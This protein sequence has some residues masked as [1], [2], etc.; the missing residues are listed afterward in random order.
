MADTE[1]KRFLVLTADAG[2]GHRSAANAVEAALLETHGEECAVDIV[3]PLDDPRVLPVLRNSGSD[4]DRLVREM[5][6]LY[7]IGYEISDARVPTAMLEGALIVMLY[8]VLRDVMD[9]VK[10]DAIVTTYPLYQSPL[11]ALS[12]IRRQHVP[13]ITVV[14]DLATVHHIWFNEAADEC[15]VAT[16][17]VRDLA[18]ASGFEADRV[19][20]T[21]IPVHPSVIRESRAP[22][23]IR[24]ALGWP[25]RTDIKTV[26]AVGSKRVGNLQGVVRALNHSG[27]PLHLV[28]VAGGDDE[29]Y[30]ELQS[31]EWHVPAHVYN[32]VDNM[33]EL[34]HAS[35]CVICKAGGLIVTESL[36]CGLPLLLVDVLPGQETGNADYVIQ[37]GAGELS[38]TPLD[39]L[40]TLCHW[41]LGG[42]VGLAQRAENAR[43]L[44]KPRAAY[45]V[46]ER[47]W[48]A[49]QAGPGTAS[50]RRLLHRSR[51]VA[52]L[53]RFQVPKV[54]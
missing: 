54:E 40:E 38:P 48:A 1:K 21:G 22:T 12:V 43:R 2:F 41:L 5:P 16:P 52:L 46:A 42:G 10:P 19:H 31:E 20:I 50:R 3:S 35:D 8:E 27:L 53:G 33:P 11:G 24:N 45:D 9:R 29:L 17:T 30:H 28:V 32:F 14:T 47:A 13:L 6:D 51:L 44:G 25:D 34:M 39:G 49:T 36:A 18:L 26:L 15:L 7:K 23:A 37:G 4:Y